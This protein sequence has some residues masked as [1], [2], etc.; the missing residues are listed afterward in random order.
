MEKP[1]G[2]KKHFE[3]DSCESCVYFQYNQNL[4]KQ[5]RIMLC[6]CVTPSFEVY[7]DDICGEYKN[8]RHEN[9]PKYALIANTEMRLIKNRS[10]LNYGLRPPFYWRDAGQWGTEIK[11]VDDGIVLTDFKSDEQLDN[12]PVIEITEEK[13]REGNR[14]YIFY[15]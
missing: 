8:I 15:L 2:Y 14:G 11:F 7:I 12:L 1:K 13:W 5:E 10:G 9:L 3:R 6:N 4:P